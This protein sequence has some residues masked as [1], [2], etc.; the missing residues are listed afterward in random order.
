[1]KTEIDKINEGVAAIENIKQQ[2]LELYNSGNRDYEDYNSLS[3]RMEKIHKEYKSPVLALAKSIDEAKRDCAKVLEGYKFETKCL[4]LEFWNEFVE[5]YSFWGKYLPLR[6]HP[7]TEAE[8]LEYKWKIRKEAFEIAKKVMADA[9]EEVK[10]I[11]E[12]AT[13][14]N[15]PVSD[16]INDV[17]LKTY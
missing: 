8:F 1:M 6:S 5:L 12:K 11:H 14:I 15:S 2:A 16:L 10:K 17:I 7:K 9:F 13:E 4:K 3:I